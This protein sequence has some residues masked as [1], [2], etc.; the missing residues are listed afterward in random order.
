[1]R[2]FIRSATALALAAACLF[3]A[4]AAR[5]DALRDAFLGL[6]S[7][8]RRAVQTE[9]ARAELYLAPTDGQWS[10]STDRALRRGADKVTQ[11][12]RGAIHPNLSRPQGIQ[13]YLSALESGKLADLLYPKP[14]TENGLFRYFSAN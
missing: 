3:G 7:D 13:L 14:T 4:P 12:T 6:S 8:S 1:M 2:P 5:A 11:V 9:L 10:S